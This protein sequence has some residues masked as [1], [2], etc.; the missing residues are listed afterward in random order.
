A[1]FD[2]YHTIEGSSSLFDCCLHSEPQ[3]VIKAVMLSAEAKMEEE[4]RNQKITD[5]VRNN[6]GFMIHYNFL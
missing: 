2:A 5:F 6:P 1:G 3:C 4:L